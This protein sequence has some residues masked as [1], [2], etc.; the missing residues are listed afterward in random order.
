MGKKSL[1]NFTLIYIC[2][3]TSTEE[4]E[5]KKVNHHEINTSDESLK[6]IQYLTYSVQ[7]INLRRQDALSLLEEYKYNKNAWSC[8]YRHLV[9]L[10]K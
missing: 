4:K 8:V 1:N 6:V 3:P 10:R 5:E 7:C 9:Y 2:E